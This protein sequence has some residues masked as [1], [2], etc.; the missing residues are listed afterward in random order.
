MLFARNGTPIPTCAVDV[1]SD[2]IATAV[3]TF[4]YDTSAVK[5]VAGKPGKEQWLVQARE[6]SR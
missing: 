3:L 2:A 5:A 6:R 4:G 1:N